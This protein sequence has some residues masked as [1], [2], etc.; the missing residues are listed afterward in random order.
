MDRA[1]LFTAG[2]GP[3]IPQL[4]P[5]SLAPEIRVSLKGGK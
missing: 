4:E 1:A 2:I 3:M 5:L